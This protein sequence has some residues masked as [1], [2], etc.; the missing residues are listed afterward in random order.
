MLFGGFLGRGL[1]GFS[2]MCV[3]RALV[4]AFSCSAF[5]HFWPIAGRENTRFVS[6]IL[7]WLFAFFCPICG[8]CRLL[9]RFRKV[10]HGNTA[11]TSGALADGR[12]KGGDHSYGQTTFPLI[13][14]RLL[15]DQLFSWPIV[16]K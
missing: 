6:P 1:T 8:I 7:G 2:E 10:L 5:S 3:F 14:R 12:A 11:T 16:A 13:T 15:C 9:A 4:S